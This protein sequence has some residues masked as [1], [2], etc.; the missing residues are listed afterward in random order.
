MKRRRAFTLI[1]T[2]V[3]LLLTAIL[4]F[5]LHGVLDTLRKNHRRYETVA[6]TM[7]RTA[8]LHRLFLNDLSQARS[9]PH[10]VHEAGYDRIDFRTDH[11]LYG[12]SM[13]WVH[14]FI[15]EKDR[16]LIRIEAVRPIDFAR[17][18]HISAQVAFFADRLALGCTTLRFRMDEN[19]VDAMV[20]CDGMDSLLISAWRGKP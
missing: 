8:F 20:R 7:V 5:Y 6:D 1:E 15:S 3:A 16:A 13:P 19:G 10:I 12:L 17:G 14:Y 4:F 2:M 9:H 18:S 11:T